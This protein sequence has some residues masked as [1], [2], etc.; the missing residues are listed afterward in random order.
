M[1][2]WVLHNFAG[3]EELVRLLRDTPCTDP[4]CDWCRDRHDARRELDRWFRFPGFRPEPLDE[5]SGQP[6]QQSI[7]EAAMAGEHVLGIL[8]TGTGKSVCYQVP[9][10]S[11][12]DK[13]GALTVV[14]SPLVA[15]MADQVEGLRKRGISSC[16]T[17]N[18]LLSMPERADALDQVR[19]GDAGILIISP[20]QLRSAT[21]RPCSGPARDS[22]LGAGRGALPVEV[23][24]R[25]PARL[26]VRGTLH[27]REGGKGAGAA[28]TVPD[29]DRQARR[30]DRN[31]GLLQE[32]ARHRPESLRRGR[33]AH[34]SEFRRGGDERGGQV[35]ADTRH[36]DV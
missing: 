32:R 24:A 5:D 36:P 11:R 18:G 21:V 31:P 9:A 20:E 25:L 10:L 14:I 16:V 2:P 26:P 19:L 6:M 35:R 4:V 23:G 22:R 12:Y 8:P 15:L 7:V 30:E 13:T 1:S 34:E 28:D 3:A 17:I 27:P 29:R 33:R